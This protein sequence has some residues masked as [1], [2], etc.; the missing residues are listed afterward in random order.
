MA[1]FTTEEEVKEVELHKEEAQDTLAHRLSESLQGQDEP[2]EVRHP[3][4]PAALVFLTYPLVLVIA[5]AG[6]IAA[7]WFFG[8]LGGAG[9]TTPA[10]P[11]NSILPPAG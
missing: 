11:P 2:M 7:L 3:L 1:V 6:I 8:V 10:V 4:A 9:S 5:I